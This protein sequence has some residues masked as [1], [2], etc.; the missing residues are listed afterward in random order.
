MSWTHI[1]KQ[2]NRFA[3]DLCM[4]PSAASRAGYGMRIS[5]SDND[6]ESQDLA[7]IRCILY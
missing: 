2:V 6:S 4:R 7:S 5:K 3:K 1:R